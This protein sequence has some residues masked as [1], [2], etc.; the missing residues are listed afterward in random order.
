[1]SFESSPEGGRMKDDWERLA[2]A[3]RINREIEAELRQALALVARDVAERVRR[4]SED[5]RA[6]WRED[7]RMQA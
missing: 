4:A 1:M 3:K 6:G 2:D 5:T 7:G